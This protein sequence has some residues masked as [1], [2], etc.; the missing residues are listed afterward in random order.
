MHHWTVHAKVDFQENILTT[1]W[2]LSIIVEY[3]NMCFSILIQIEIQQQQDDIVNQP[4]PKTFSSQRG[5]PLNI[6]IRQS[7]VHKGYYPS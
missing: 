5:C 4:K 6:Q 7:K 3:N 1:L 2:I